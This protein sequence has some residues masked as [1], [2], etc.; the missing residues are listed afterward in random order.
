M[1]PEGQAKTGEDLSKLDSM[2]V[3]KFACTSYP[4]QPL[5]NY[6]CKINAIE[7]MPI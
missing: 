5:P 6:T 7:P 4:L 1:L 2:N 3:L